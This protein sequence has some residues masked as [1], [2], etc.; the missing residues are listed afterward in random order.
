MKVALSILYMMILG[1]YSVCAQSEEMYSHQALIDQGYK[2]TNALSSF[3]EYQ[4]PKGYT[5]A[6]L[7][8]K[9]DPNGYIIILIFDKNDAYYQA[10]SKTRITEETYYQCRDP[11]A[12]YENGLIKLE[13]RWMGGL[14]FGTNLLFKD[15]KLTF[16]NS[17]DYNVNEDV[18]AQAEE[19]KQN[20]DPVSYCEAYMEAQ[21]YTGL[22]EKVIESLRWAHKKAMKYYQAKDYQQ[23]SQLMVA[24]E[25]RCGFAIEIYEEM[26]EDFVSIWGD[27]TLFHLKAG[28]N[29]SCIRIAQKLIEYEPKATGVYLQYGDALFNLKKIAESKK[30]YQKYIA[31][32][33][34]AGKTP[35]IP[36]RALKRG[37]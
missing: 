7:A 36:S 13:C 18:Y 2:I 35:Q 11:Y 6:F 23:A 1:G 5:Q 19:A 22:T 37:Q 33:K 25:E 26:G 24:L 20:D 15:Q 34:E 29:E 8:T 4:L 9:E 17:Y 32:M 27:V 10:V 3:P 21:F 14:T 28:D 12:F 30:I 16:V 31:L